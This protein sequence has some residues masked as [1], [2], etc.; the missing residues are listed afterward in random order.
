MKK[1]IGK[2][3]FKRDRGAL[4]PLTPSFLC[5]WLFPITNILILR[6]NCPNSYNCYHDFCT[7][8]K[9][10]IRQLDRQIDRQIDRYTYIMWYY[11]KLPSNLGPPLNTPR[12]SPRC[13]MKI[14]TKFFSRISHEI[15]T[16]CFLGS[17]AY[18]WISE[19]YCVL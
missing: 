9:T 15:Q 16:Q 12:T 14:F 8:Q 19:V 7:F 4:A 1:S 10:K 17:S 5:Q 2:C 3:F 6:P 13:P 18:N 11:V